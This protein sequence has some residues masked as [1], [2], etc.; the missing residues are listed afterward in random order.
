[1]LAG[2]AFNQHVVASLLTADGTIDSAPA[3]RLVLLFQAGAIGWG[4]LTILLGR[5][6]WVINANLTLLSLL[7][8]WPLLG[9]ALIRAGTSIGVAYFREPSL[10]ADPYADDDYWK[11]AHRWG[12]GVSDLR[13]L[14]PDSLLGWAP[15]VTMQ[16]PFGLAGDA[17][18]AVNMG[19]ESMLFYGDSFVE[20]ATPPEDRIPKIVGQRLRAYQVLNFGVRGYGLDQIYLRYR[21][22]VEKFE[23]PNLVFGIL[24]VD[25]DRCVLRV[26]S[27]PKPFFTVEGDTLVLNGIPVSL[28]TGM[29][30]KAHPPGIMSYHWAFWVRKARLIAARGREFALPQKRHAKE[31]ICRLTIQSIVRESAAHGRRLLFVIFH[32]M[33]TLAEPDWRHSLLLSVLSEHD[34]PFVDTEDVLLPR[35]GAH[36]HEADAYYD[37]GNRHLNSQGNR[38]VA[39]AIAKR[40]LAEYGVG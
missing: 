17:P 39:Q 8:V 1:M 35:G 24:T 32:P 11:L 5:R 13:T 23:R 15:S 36:R 2:A 31:V 30:F 16:N 7:L 38:A 10:Y 25:L 3:T 37:R 40:W 19:R 18:R 4:M 21:N 33:E 28:D 26:R 9:E 12:S 14:M 34:V 29:W 22:T 27:G 6:D 20:G